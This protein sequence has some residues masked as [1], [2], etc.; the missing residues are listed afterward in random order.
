MCYIYVCIYI[1]IYIYIHA[2][3]YLDNLH[4]LYLFPEGPDIIIDVR[5]C[6]CKVSVIF[7]RF[8][9]KINFSK[10]PQYNFL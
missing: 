8:K 1:H 10:N 9:E 4:F 5:K 3:L 6:S 7:V 2:K